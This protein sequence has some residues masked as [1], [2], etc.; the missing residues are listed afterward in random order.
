MGVSTRP[1]RLGGT[2]DI[3]KLRA[4]LD[5]IPNNDLGW[6]EWNRIGMAIYAATSGSAAGLDLFH[7]WSKKSRKYNASATAEKW[8][9]LRS[10]PPTEIS[11]GTIFF[12]ADSADPEWRARYEASEDDEQPTEEQPD[13][14]HADEAWWREPADIPPRQFLFGRHYVR[15]YI[16][17]SIGAG[18]RCKTSLATVDA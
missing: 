18:G 10:C 9:A 16:G 2:P 5:A 14:V 4:A 15:R 1:A 8:H 13:A 7:S 12:E 11:A 6:E 17:A 3:E